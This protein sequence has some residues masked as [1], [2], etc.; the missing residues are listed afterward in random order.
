MKDINFADNEKENQPPE[1]PQV[2]ND[3]AILGVSSDLFILLSN[4]LVIT[5]PMSTCYTLGGYRERV[6]AC[7]DATFTQRPVPR[8]VT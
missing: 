8:I 2:P 5:S 4:I 7:Y 6:K 1:Q 3:P